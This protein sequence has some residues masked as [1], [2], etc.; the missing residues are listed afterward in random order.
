MPR[1]LG[2]FG[3]IVLGKNIIRRRTGLFFEMSGRWPV[4]IAVKYLGTR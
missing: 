2:T 1:K 4:Q 3:E